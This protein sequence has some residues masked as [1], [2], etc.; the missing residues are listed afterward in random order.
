MTLE[1]KKARIAELKAKLEEMK[2]AQQARASK[3]GLEGAAA[4]MMSE[5]PDKAMRWMD[6]SRAL[7]IKEGAKGA[8]S[9]PDNIRFKMISRKNAIDGL[10]A[11]LGSSDPDYAALK[12]ES[13]L[14]G[15]EIGKDSPSIQAVYGGGAM[16]G[17][18]GNG[19]NAGTTGG[20]PAARK[21]AIERLAKSG[22]LRPVDGQIDDDEPLGNDIDDIISRYNL[23]AADADAIRKLL[24]NKRTTLSNAFDAKAG[25]TAL[26]AA[27]ENLAQQKYENWLKNTLPG[28]DSAS[29]ELATMRQGFNSALAQAKRSPIGGA[30]IAMKGVLRDALS[31]ADFSGI[32]G[33]GVPQGI[34]GKM[35]A[36]LGA[37]VLTEAQAKEI[38][39]SAL[40][41]YND[42]V[43]E[44][45]SQLKAKSAGNPTFAAKAIKA[46]AASPL[47]SG[48]FSNVR[49][50]ANKDE[51][52]GKPVL[53][54]ATKGKTG[55]STWEVV[56]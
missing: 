8:S 56:K 44:Y 22:D 15:A 24:E 50:T 2:A 38:V 31:N 52:A 47:N 39:I 1:E 21:E 3:A 12:K 42:A 43:A 23:K 11:R 19:D 28:V 6:D 33:M 48:E 16:P 46:Y 41:G 30:Y 13:D 49:G 51:A 4:R 53:P 37:S 18:N 45:N 32:A 26:A 40:S 14:L 10:M 34:I 5:D 7:D 25:Q 35:K 20:Y 36:A 27:N 17:G 9:D 29:R 54:K 55:K